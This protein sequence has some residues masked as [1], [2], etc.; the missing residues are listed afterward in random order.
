MLGTIAAFG[1]LFWNGYCFF[2]MYLDKEK[3]I[4]G[5]YRISEKKL[6]KYGFGFGAFGIA[7]G[8]MAFSHKTK[9]RNFISLVV[10]A[11]L[12]NILCMFLLLMLF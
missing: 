2:L 5:D 3:A 4:H 11:I 1:Y 6:I 12:L 8:M 7:F 9:K 10:L